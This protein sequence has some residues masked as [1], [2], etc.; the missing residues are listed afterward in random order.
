MVQIY[1]YRITSTQRS[2]YRSWSRYYN[3]NHFQTNM[4]RAQERSWHKKKKW[5]LRFRDTY[6][7]WKKHDELM[8]LKSWDLQVPSS[9]L[10]EE[11]CE[12]LFIFWHTMQQKKF[13]FAKRRDLKYWENIRMDPRANNGAVGGA[14]EDGKPIGGIN[15]DSMVCSINSVFRNVIFMIKALTSQ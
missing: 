10:K 6:D 9:L 12:P 5:S 1:K 8:K 2:L 3:L 13:F 7:V 4:W 14:N 15:R 11:K